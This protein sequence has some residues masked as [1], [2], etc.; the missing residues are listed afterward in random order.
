MK[1]ASGNGRRTVL[2]VDDEHG[3]PAGIVTLE[4]AIET[5]LGREI[6]DESDRIE[7]L[8]ELAKEKYRDRLHEDDQK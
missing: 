2:L 4:D 7:D 1:E 3:Q 8:Q 6:V 5:L